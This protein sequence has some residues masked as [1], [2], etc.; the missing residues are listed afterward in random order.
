MK[1]AVNKSAIVGLTVLISASL[2]AAQD[3]REPTQLDALARGYGLLLDGEFEDAAAFYQKIA[4]D[5]GNPDAMRRAA[6]EGEAYA[7]TAKYLAEHA[8]LGENF[9]TKKYR[10]AARDAVTAAGDPAASYALGYLSAV[11][12]YGDAPELAAFAEHS[13]YW[14]FNRPPEPDE[15]PVIGGPV[16]EVV[17]AVALEETVDA[18]EADVAAADSAPVEEDATPSPP[19]TEVA[20][21]APAAE[22][23]VAEAPTDAEGP[24]YVTVEGGTGAFKV[25]G[26]EV[27]LR[28]GPGTAYEQLDTLEDGVFLF[29]LQQVRNSQGEFWSEV[30]YQPSPTSQP[31]TG[32]VTNTYILPAQ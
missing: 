2:A 25:N 21:A 16:E 6:S 7:L 3:G 10:E 13:A 20:V 4:G 27:R 29:V 18:N 1:R 5:S 31:V 32:F 14:E 26:S 19:V 23:P 30:S 15:I 17:A 22:E 9:V 28:A 24:D 8:Q 12:D 11:I